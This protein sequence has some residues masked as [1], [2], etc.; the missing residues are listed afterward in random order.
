MCA[1]DIK[2]HTLREVLGMICLTPGHADKEAVSLLA[3]GMLLGEGDL[4]SVSSVF[5]GPQAKV[6][7]E[8]E[9]SA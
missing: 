8:R 7:G 6:G 1:G 4:A 2:Q 9:A 5:T 3:A